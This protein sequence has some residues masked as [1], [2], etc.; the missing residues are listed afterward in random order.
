MQ[1]SALTSDY[2]DIRNLLISGVDRSIKSFIIFKVDI[3]NFFLK[4]KIVYYVHDLP[5]DFPDKLYPS[6]IRT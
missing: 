2:V 1:N 5:I 3:Y 4:S 6:L